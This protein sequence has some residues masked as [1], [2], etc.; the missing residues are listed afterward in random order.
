[1]TE[2]LQYSLNVSNKPVFML[3]LDAQS[4][5]DRCL[6]QILCGELYKSGVA[7][8]AILFMDNRLES[9]LT[10]YEWDGQKMGPAKDGTGF[11][12]GGINSSDYYKVYNNEQLVTAQSSELGV[13]VGS[14]VISAVGQADDVLLL[15]NDIYSLK[16]LVKLT[17]D[18]CKKYRVKLEPKKTKLLGYCTKKTELLVKLAAANDIITIDGTPVHFTNEA[19]HVGVVRNTAG[20]MPNILCR[21][22]EHKRALGAVLSVGMAR[23]HSGSPAAALRVHQLHCMPVLFSGLSSLVL[24]SG[25]VKIIDKHYQFTL[26]SLQRLHQR[27]PRSII[28]FL[29][30]SL[31]GEAHLHLKQLTLFS[32]ICHLPEDPLHHHAK[33]AMTNLAPSSLSWFHQIRNI[34]LQYS[35]PHPFT[36]LET[37]LSKTRFNN[38][39]K[40]MVTEYW[41]QVLV[42][43]CTSPSLSSLRY[44]DP[45]KASLSQPHPIWTSTAGNGYE[46]GKGTI[47]AR[48]VSGRYRT[49]MMCRFWSTNKEGYCLAPTCN[50][51]HGDL[52]H[53]LVVCPALDHVR[54]RLH[55]L[56]LLKTADCPPLQRLL[57]W[58]LGSPP[59]T[60]V[61][62][63]LDSTACPQ[64]IT[65]IQVFGPEIMHRVCYL[66]RTWAFSIH[67]HKM[68]LLG[69]WPETVKTKKARPSTDLAIPLQSL[70]NNDPCPMGSTHLY[71]N[72]ISNSSYFPALMN[73][74]QLSAS[75]LPASTA[76]PPAGFDTLGPCSSTTSPPASTRVMPC[77]VELF[78]PRK[79]TVQTDHQ[80][81]AMPGPSTITKSNLS[82]VNCVVGLRGNLTGHGRSHGVMDCCPSSVSGHQHPESQK[83]CQ[84]SRHYNCPNSCTCSQP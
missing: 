53:L 12:Q 20:N 73:L 65:M 56:W 27:T 39:A 4:A 44:F 15:S 78:V 43:E 24:N 16:L 70:N 42:A 38:L 37:P 50:L 74:P 57:M 19:E 9:R 18:Y 69:R 28:F 67:R 51:V 83:T 52:E 45:L 32:M 8:S 29:A 26:Q 71:N 5:F 82:S 21:V 61:R 66:T 33:Y 60:Q 75:T 30:V 54:H 49:E 68:K 25:E 2:V 1:M 23:G 3:S 41:R 84:S 40:L 46:C 48:M 6:R 62:F 55:S 72:L 80:R 11:E 13:D 63:I 35:L 31:P 10:V 7:G 79:T 47:L 64:L 76:S 36:L 17:E 34:C 77:D 22:A 81:N 59:D 58:I 14:A